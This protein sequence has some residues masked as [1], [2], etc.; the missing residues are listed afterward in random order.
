M[1]YSIK[2]SVVWITEKTSALVLCTSWWCPDDNVTSY[3]LSAGFPCQVC[4][5]LANVYGSKYLVFVTSPT[6]CRTGETLALAQ[7]TLL[8]YSVSDAF[9]PKQVASGAGPF[10][11]RKNTLHA[12]G[13]SVGL[14]RKVFVDTSTQLKH[15]SLKILR[16]WHHATIAPLTYSRILPSKLTQPGVADYVIPIAGNHVIAKLNEYLFHSFGAPVG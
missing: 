7:A 10:G 4:D 13:F 1:K 16:I 3:V 8:W 5:V 9:T 11:M 6:V 14:F 2:P 15:E 12:L